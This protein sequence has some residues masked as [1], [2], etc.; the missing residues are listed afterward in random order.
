M[1]PRLRIIWQRKEEEDLKMKF[2]AFYIWNYM[3]VLSFILW[4]LLLPGSLQHP[5]HVAQSGFRIDVRWETNQ[6]TR[7]IPVQ[8]Q[9]AKCVPW[10]FEYLMDHDVNLLYI[11]IYYHKAVTLQI[12]HWRDM[13]IILPLFHYI[14]TILKTNNT[15]NCRPK[16]GM[17]IY[18]TY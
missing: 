6:K 3:Q 7:C 18:T 1:L 5:Y 17:Y 4:L 2:H 14:F 12:L 10:N 11:K 9:S 15:T 16:L 8:S 13:E